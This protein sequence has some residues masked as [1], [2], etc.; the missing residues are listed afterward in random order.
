MAAPDQDTDQGTVQDTDQG[1]VQEPSDAELVP[2]DEEER[3]RRVGQLL[4]DSD[5]YVPSR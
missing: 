2:V 5:P 4:H 3:L 1:T